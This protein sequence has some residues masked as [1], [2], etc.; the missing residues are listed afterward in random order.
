MHSLSV[1][2]KPSATPWEVALPLRL[3]R[4]AEAR[5]TDGV[6]T[7]VLLYERAD[8]STFRYRCYNVVQAL[9]ASR[10]WRA[11]Y[12]FKDELEALAPFLDRADLLVVARFRWGP[13]LDRIMMRAKA[14]HIP[15]LFD[16]DDMV[17]DVRYIP[18]IANTLN[19]GLATQEDNDYWFAYV[20]RLGFAASR[21]DGFTTTND[22]LGRLLSNSFDHPYWLVR[23]S[24]NDEQAIY[25]ERCR[26]A[27]AGKPD[28]KPF[29]IGYFSGTPSHV[30]DFAEVQAEIGQLLDDFPDVVLSVVGFMDFSGELAHH[31]ASGRVRYRPLVDFLELQRLTA[32]VDVNIAPLV[33]NAFTQCK[34]N[35]KFFEAG[36]VNTVTLATP[37]FAFRNSIIDGENGFLCRPGEWYPRIRELLK[38]EKSTS[39]IS[40]NALRYALDNHYGDSVRTEIET[41]YS[42]AVERVA[43]NA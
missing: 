21:A 38:G 42:R 2:G 28:R 27:K 43:G 4:L 5:G 25:S 14:R 26:A 11:V 31:I 12:F 34:S 41:S 3:A 9:R 39:R 33:D 7:A 17:F 20:S 10:E 1:P 37:T 13:E 29:T 22:Y 30:N 8:T 15:I 18:L 23:N 35:L 24:V 16:I 6:R 19:V 32:E 36:L 40:A